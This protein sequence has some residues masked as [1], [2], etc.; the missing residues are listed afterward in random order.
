MKAPAQPRLRARALVRKDDVRKAVAGAITG[1]M[2]V[3]RIEFDLPAGKFFLWAVDPHAPASD[4][5]DLE[6]RMREAF[7]E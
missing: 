5:A 7:D 4:A 2:P 6:R 1:G 3:G